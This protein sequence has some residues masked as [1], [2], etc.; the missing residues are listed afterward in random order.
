V[1]LVPFYEEI[2]FRGIF[3]SA[4]ERNM[5][6]MYANIL[7]SIVFALVHQN[8]KLFVF[9]FA[10]GMIAGYYRQKSQGLII[11]T[12]MHMMNNLL[13]FAAIALRS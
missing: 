1:L 11:G 9:Y 8:L 5:R 13:A 2:L 10:F 6:F 12:S 4:C 3:L 7:Q